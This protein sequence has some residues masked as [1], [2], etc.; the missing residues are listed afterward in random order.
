[1]ILQAIAQLFAAIG[2]SATNLGT[3][4]L[5]EYISYL[6]FMILMMSMSIVVWIVGGLIRHNGNSG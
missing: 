1:M 5:D 2:I 4:M 3:L 6:D